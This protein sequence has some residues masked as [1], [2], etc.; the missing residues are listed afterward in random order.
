MSTLNVTLNLLAA[1]TALTERYSCT[2]KSFFARA[3]S[4]IELSKKS[5]PLDTPASLLREQEHEIEV[6]WGASMMTSCG[7]SWRPG[8]KASHAR[9]CRSTRSHRA[10]DQ[11]VTR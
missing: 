3:K 1:F 10:G 11:H 7:G 4:S 9:R 8:L 6:N 2:T 5:S